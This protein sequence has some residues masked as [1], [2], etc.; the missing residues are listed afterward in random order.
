MPLDEKELE[1]GTEL[2]LQRLEE[3]VDS[4][5]EVSDIHDAFEFYCAKRYS[6]GNSASNHRVGGKDDL[7]VDFYSQS[8]HSY[9]VGQ[10]KIPERD[11]LEANPTK[12]KLF[13]PSA[14]ADPRDALRY[15]TGDSD[16]KANERVQQL[17]ALVEGDRSQDDF[18][19]TMYLVVYGR[20]N[21]RG[22]ESFNE[23]KAEYESKCFSVIL[24]EIDDL[25]EEFLVGAAHSKEEI[26]FDLRTDTNQL[27]RAPK[28]CYFLA[29]VADLY[30]ATAVRLKVEQNQLVGVC[31]GIGVLFDAL[32]GA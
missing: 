5:P 27:L 20:L 17:Y 25:V 30:K 13:G 16:L 9:H 31:G 4:E 15:L 6:L 24:Q 2:F 8:D 19:L 12:P 23:L 11:W 3:I 32:K 29:N 18:S 7:G 28:Y 1:L 21:S 26:T 14:I 10:C 22:R